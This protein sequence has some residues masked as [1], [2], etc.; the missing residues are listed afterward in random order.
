MSTLKLFDTTLRDGAQGEGVSYSTH[1]KLQIAQILDK[2][3][4]HYIEG[5]WPGSN[6]KDNQF[7]KDIRSVKLHQAKIVAFGSTRRKHTKAAQDAN[8]Q[9]IAATKAPVACIFG[10][11]WDMQVVH[12]LQTTLEENLAMIRDSV[13]FLKTKHEEVIYDAEHFFDGFRANR[14]YALKALQAALEAGADN[15]TLC[16]T[17][18]GSL[19]SQI[20]EVMKVVKRVLPK[21]KWGIHAHNDSGCA[22]ANTIASVEGGVTL[23]QG[24]M[25]G[26]GERTGNADLTAVIPNLQLKMGHKVITDVQL[27]S[28]T[29]VARTICEVT[30]MVPLD[31]QP[32]VGNSAFAHKGGVHV[33][34]VA[35]HAATYEHI[36]PSIVG[37]RRRVLISELS[38]KSNV[39]LK[40][41]DLRTDFSKDEKATLKILDV[42]KKRESE[43]FHYEGAEASFELLVEKTLDRHRPSFELEGFRVV[44]ERKPGDPKDLI[45]E[46]T[47]KISVDGHR[48]HTVAEGDGPVNALD[49][50]LRKALEKFY[51]AVKQTSLTDYKVRVVNGAEGTAAKVR[52]LIESVDSKD[53]QEW[54]TTGVSTNLIEASWQ[55]LVDAIEY[56]LFRDAH[57]RA[58]PASK[59]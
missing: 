10:K 51:P 2:F 1:D 7:F 34:A 53:Q 29:E 13:A 35:R 9:L 47:L 3:G 54:T 15:L 40:S 39:V 4:M 11:S 59:K 36:D 43:G 6:P 24:T 22:I 50:A 25:N 37:N 19:P 12:A 27:H 42:L 18:G 26:I 16:D 46:A 48:E 57:K 33:S 58:K 55:A 56:K 38:G 28:L 5:G 14:P 32:Y 41:K 23:I 30:N 21:A 8:L 52:V 44:V 45:T 20:L 17:N 31:R 49:N